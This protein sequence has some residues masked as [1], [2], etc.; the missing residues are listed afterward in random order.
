VR[1]PDDAHPLFVA[2][3]RRALH[4]SRYDP[5][6]IGG[7][8]VAQLVEQQFMFRITHQGNRAGYP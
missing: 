4:R 1:F 7:R 3:I 6:M 8:P 5:A 2:S